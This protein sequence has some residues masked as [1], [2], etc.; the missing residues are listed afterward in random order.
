MAYHSLSRVR[1]VRNRFS[2]GICP[3]AKEPLGQ[4]EL[5][6][7]Q[8]QLLPFA[9]GFTVCPFFARYFCCGL[10]QMEATSEAHFEGWST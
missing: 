8:V 10:V 6:Q 5:V 2:A 4:E 1:F 9:A 7:L 3:V